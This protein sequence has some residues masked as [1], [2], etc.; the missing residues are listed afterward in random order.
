MYASGAQ[1]VNTAPVLG[2]SALFALL[3]TVIAYLLYY[4]GIQKIRDSSRVPVQASVECVVAVGIGVL[5]L[6]E[7]LGTVKAL[8]IA[9]VLGSVL[10]MNSG[11]QKPPA[12]EQAVFDWAFAHAVAFIARWSTDCSD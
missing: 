11:T 7:T 3:P 12:H 2:W 5:A 9:R 4:R 8:G 10:L 1:G 6:H